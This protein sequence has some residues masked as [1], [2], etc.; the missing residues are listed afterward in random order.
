ML[1]L[2]LG[3]IDQA[4]EVLD[5]GLTLSGERGD[6]SSSSESRSLFIP[7]A[8][9]NESLEMSDIGSGRGGREGIQMKEGVRARRCRGE[10]VGG[11]EAGGR[12]VVLGVSGVRPVGL[13][14]GWEVGGG[15]R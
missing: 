13:G 7:R 10:S 8:S 9:F 5:S 1:S 12:G 14:R 3:L 11:G 2:G 4:A 15:V 6:K